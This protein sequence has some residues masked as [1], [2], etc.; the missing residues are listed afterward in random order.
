MIFFFHLQFTVF[1]TRSTVLKSNISGC[2]RT[3]TDGCFFFFLRFESTSDIF[4]VMSLN[5]SMLNFCVMDISN[6]LGFS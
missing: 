3:Y 5:A 6:I 2:L 4:S 1:L